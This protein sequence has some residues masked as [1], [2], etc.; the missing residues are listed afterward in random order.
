[1][2]SQYNL[3]EALDALVTLT[4]RSQKLVHA[5]QQK[6]FLE[7][8]NKPSLALYTGCPEQFVPDQIKNQRL[9]PFCPPGTGVNPDPP[10]GKKINPQSRKQKRPNQGSRGPFPR[11]GNQ[12]AKKN[13]E[14][15]GTVESLNFFKGLCNIEDSLLVVFNKLSNVHYV[16]G[17][18][19]LSSYTLTKSETSVLSKGLGFCPTP[20]APD[21][22]NIIQ[23]LDVFKRKTKLNLFFSESNQDSRGHNT[24]P[25]VPFEHKFLKLKS[26][27][28]PVGPFQLETMFHSIEQDLHRL[29][30]RQPRKKNLTKEE[31]KSIKSLRNHP[32]IIIK[33]ADKGSAIVILDKQYYINEGERQLH[34]NHFYEETET[35]LTG[36][37]IHRVNLYVNNMLQ[38]GQISQNTSKYLTTD[39]DRKQQFYL[40]PEIHK[41]INNPPGRPIVSGSGGT[42][43]QNIPVC[44]PFHRITSTTV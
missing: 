14:D 3:N 25:G 5:E 22:G 13:Q 41:D 43:R 44:G 34:N 26:T 24:P 19:D 17:I 30:H 6:K 27:F 28:N 18:V 12:Q 33:P 10:R 1:M 36:E 16:S 20:G 21:I 39:I 37:V 42:H 38:R 7:L 11:K 35:D 29:K 8:S 40:L 4:D 2:A 9:Q 31:Y 15:F 32:D 23:D